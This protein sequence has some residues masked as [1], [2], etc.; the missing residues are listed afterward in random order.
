[1]LGVS[2][3]NKCEYEANNRPWQSPVATVGIP[4]LPKG[5][6]LHHKFG[7]VDGQTVI[8]GSHNWSEARIPTMMR[9]C[10]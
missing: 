4:Q 6:V 2:L 10:W 5:D 9:H 1:M 3:A 7:V 8:T